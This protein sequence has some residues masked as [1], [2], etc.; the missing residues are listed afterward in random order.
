MKISFDIGQRDSG[1]L[2]VSSAARR[3][4][5]ELAI[6][7]RRGGTRLWANHGSGGVC[8]PAL[9]PRNSGKAHGRKAKVSNRTWEIRLY[10]II[11]GPP[12]TQ[13]WWK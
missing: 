10:G 1:H 4:D 9:K 6:S 13:P 2:V 3:P 5:T 11:G 7:R 12:E 8:E